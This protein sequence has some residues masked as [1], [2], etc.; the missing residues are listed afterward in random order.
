MSYTNKH[1][2]HFIH[3]DSDKHN[4]H[5]HG[6]RANLMTDDAI[7]FTFNYPL[8]IA[9]SE[10][11]KIPMR[12]IRQA[13]MEE[14]IGRHDMIKNSTI[15]EILNHGFVEDYNRISDVMASIYKSDVTKSRCHGLFSWILGSNDTIS[16]NFFVVDTGYDDFDDTNTLISIDGQKQLPYWKSMQCNNLRGVTVDKMFGPNIDDDDIDMVKIY[17]PNACRNM[18]WKVRYICYIAFR[19]SDIFYISILF[20]YR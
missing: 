9:L 20:L 7:I 6:P 19:Y 18:K 17:E 2:Y 5:S 15:S 14:L 12:Q 1:K 11:S 13:Y 8:I 10:I 3:P 4:D 16:D